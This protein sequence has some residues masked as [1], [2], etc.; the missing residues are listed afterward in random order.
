[1]N[2]IQ[3][4]Q[5]LNEGKQERVAVSTAKINDAE[6]EYLQHKKDLAPEIR[7]DIANFRASYANIKEHVIYKMMKKHDFKFNLVDSE[8]K[9]ISSLNPKVDV[10][11]EAKKEEPEKPKTTKPA[12]YEKKDYKNEKRDIYEKTDYQRDSNDYQNR[13]KPRQDEGLE[14]DNKKSTWVNK[15]QQDG[16]K[17]VDSYRHKQYNDYGYVPKNAN[18]ARYTKKYPQAGDQ[19]KPRKH[20]YRGSYDHN[21]Y[22]IYVPKTTQAKAPETKTEEGPVLNLLDLS[23]EQSDQ[24]EHQTNGGQQVESNGHHELPKSHHHDISLSNNNRYDLETKYDI[25][26]LIGQGI[27]KL[28]SIIYRNYSAYFKHLLATSYY[29]DYKAE[30]KD[31]VDLKMNSGDKK[32]HGA[33]AKK[34]KRPVTKNFEIEENDEESS[35]I[36]DKIHLSVLSK[37]KFESEEEKLKVHK[38]RNLENTIKELSLQVNLLTSKLQ[39]FENEVQHLQSANQT[40][41]EQN[42]LAPKNDSQELYC[43]VPFNLVKDLFT[44]GPLTDQHKSPNGLPVF[45]LTPSNKN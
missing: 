3:K 43:I 7:Q 36:K 23:K 22:D 10:N 37:P 19:Y 45:K 41:R 1:M 24:N 13:Q 5:R 20:N 4:M 27:Q 32:W 44:L 35:G 2:I 34:K 25:N 42:Q 15:R 40:L 18:S 9:F 26:G 14:S 6:A 16:Y 39:K 11:T 8:L 31:V 30:K 21:D 28:I 12:K 29:V 17:N 38:E 33:D